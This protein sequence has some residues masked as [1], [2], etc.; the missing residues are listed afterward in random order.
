MKHFNITDYVDDFKTLPLASI[1]SFQDPNEQLDTL[2]NLILECIERH[3]PLVKAKFTSPPA[4]WMKQLDIA[5]LRKTGTIIATWH[6]ILQ[7]K[8]IGQNLEISAINQNQKSK[9]QRQLFTKKKLSSKN[10][11]EIWKVVHR[12]LKPNDNTLKVDTNKLNKYSN[13]TATRLVSRKSM[14]K[15]ELTGLID[16]FNDKENAFQL[17]QVTYENTERCIKMT[18]NDCSTG[19][20]HILA[21]F[22]KP[23]SQFLVSPITFIINNFIKINQF[24][25]IWTLARIS[26]I[27]K[28][29][30]PV[31][32]KDYRPVSILPILSKADERVVLEQITDFIEK[33]LIYHHYQSGYRKNHSTTILLV[34]LRDDIKEALKASEITL[35][36]FTHYSKAFDNIDFSVLIKKIHTLNL[37]DRRHFVQ[38]DSNISNILYTN[39]GVTQGSILGPF[40]N[41]C[42]ADMKSILNGSKCIQYADDSTIY[43]SWTKKK[44]RQMFKRNR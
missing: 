30:L 1:Y 21:T 35:A 6:I 42:V 8:K 34:K 32:L 12:I 43:R 36:V 39:F 33:K 27:P 25:D 44:N 38:I 19:S 29:Q 7:L 17:Q 16:S 2:N 15:K 10:S 18:R 37:T 23:V 13:D 3:A 28:I 4:P 24:P 26:P 11:K 5:D 22:I 31:E 41:L 9:R 40:F 14:S 20:Y